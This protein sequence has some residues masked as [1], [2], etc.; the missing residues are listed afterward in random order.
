M[1]R[2]VIL[3]AGNV[4]AHLF[5]AFFEAKNVVVVQVYNRSKTAL[6]PFSEKTKTTVS[7]DELEEADVYLIC[8]KDDAVKSLAGKIPFKNKLIVHTSGSVPLLDVSEKNGVFYPLQTFSKEV[9]VDFSKIPICLEAS[10]ENSFKILQNL[11]GSISER[12][13]RISTEQR[14]SLHLAAVF[15]CNFTNYLYR[16]GE[17]ICEENEVPFEILHAL[18]EETARKATEKSPKETQTGPA[19]RGD[20]KTIDQHLEQLKNPGFKE[21][22]TLLSQKIKDISNKLKRD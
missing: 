2:I 22:Y 4:A 17:E 20:Q 1:L 13:Y 12:N 11:A 19:V 21:I 18:M 15:V 7:L 10:D 3:G 9:P 5:Q 14:K 16:V 6:K 8:A